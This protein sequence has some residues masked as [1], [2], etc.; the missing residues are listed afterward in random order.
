[1]MTGFDVTAVM[2]MILDVNYKLT[3][4]RSSLY[5]ERQFVV[6]LIKDVDPLSGGQSGNPIKYKLTFAEDSPSTFTVQ[7]P[8][9]H[10]LWAA[11]L[12]ET[13]HNFTGSSNLTKHLQNASLSLLG[14]KFVEANV[15]IAGD[16]F[17]SR[18]NQDPAAAGLNDAAT[19]ELAAL[20]AV[21]RQ[22]F[23][24]SLGQYEALQARSMADLTPAIVRGMA[25]YLAETYGWEKLPRFHSI[26]LGAVDFGFD[27]A[28]AHETFVAAC[29]SAAFDADLLTLCRDRWGFPIDEAF[30]FEILAKLSARAALRDEPVLE[31][32]DINGDGA[33]DMRDVGILAHY[34][35]QESPAADIGPVVADG[36]VDLYDLAMLAD[37]WLDA[38]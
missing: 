2:D 11:Y 27:V 10:P 32:G 38:L 1:M 8:S 17:T 35:H 12:H 33:V 28:Q 30:Y 29:F 18:F 37:Y 16:Y 22:A 7:T 3:G 19:D 20:F 4:D 24:W 23:M 15:E 26:F 21:R 31:R 13:G 6:G 9:G 5:G 25:G 34:W 36:M 14:A